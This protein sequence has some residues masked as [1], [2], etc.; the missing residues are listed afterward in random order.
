M[1]VRHYSMKDGLPDE[2]VLA[3]I[4]DS[5]GFIWLGTYSGLCKFDGYRF[6][7]YRNNPASSNSLKSNLINSLL[8]DER[9]RIWIA[10]TQGVDLFD[11]RTEKF[12]FHWPDSADRKNAVHALKLVKQRDGKIWI[13]TT[14]G[15]YGA[16]PET[17]KIEKSPQISRPVHDIGET[18]NGSIVYADFL[19]FCYL[20]GKTGQTIKFTH[21]PLNP[22]TIS[23]GEVWG[24]MI[25]RRDRIWIGTST[26]LELFNP[27]EKT[28]THYPTNTHVLGI[29]ENP[30]GTLFLGT[31]DGLFLFDPEHTNRLERL[32]EG[33]HVNSFTRDR[34][35]NIW[36]S[37]L[38]GL[39]QLYPNNKKFNIHNQFGNG[40]GS[41]IE[42]VNQ[43]I[44]LLG[45][46]DHE[47]LSTVFKF[48]LATGDVYRYPRNSKDPWTWSLFTD[49]NKNVWLASSSSLEKC[50]PKNQTFNVVN[51][52]QTS[53]LAPI[54]TFVDSDGTIW[55][56]AWDGIGKINPVNGLIERMA[57]FPKAT[58]YSFLEDS[59]QNLWIGSTAGLARYN[60]KTGKLDFFNNQS[61]DPQSLSSNV[62]YHLLMDSHKNIWVGTS[63]GLNKMIKG[64]ESNI[65]R[66]TNW[67]TS[68]SGLPYDDVFCI[69]D[70]GDGT[71]WITS[72]NM[73]AHF[74]P[75]QNIFHNYDIRDGLS[76][77]SFR[78]AFFLNGKG[79][80]NHDGNILFGSL[81]G[82][83]VFHPDSLE[84]NKFVP[85]IVI[86]DFSIQNQR[87]PVK[88][89]DADTLTWETPLTK[90]IS[91]TDEIRLSYDQNNFNLE[92]AAL[93][94]ISP[95]RSQYKYKLE[96]YEKDWIETDA[97]NRFAHYTNIDPGKYTF[98]VIGSNNDGIWNEK[99][100]SLVIIITPPWWKT[101][102]AYTL[103]SLALIGTF[104]FWRN[105][106]NKR[107]KLKHRAEH[108]SEL[109]NLKTRFFTNI[110]HEFRTPITLIL[111]PLKEMYKGT[112]KGDQRSV[113]GVMLRNAQ[114]LSKLINQLLDLS[115]LEAGKMKLRS[116]PVD[117]V[118]FLKEITSS[119]ES[120]AAD[121]KIKYFFYPEV[122]ELIAYIDAEKIEK[123]VHNLLSNAFKFTKEDGEVIINLKAEEKHFSISV[124]DTGIG[125]PANQLNQIF[126]RFYQVDSTQTREYEG[127]G[128]GMTLAKEL[129]ELHHGTIAVESAEG[130]G[131]TFIVRLPLGKDH[132]NKDEI[133]D[134]ENLK[135][136]EIVYEDIIV[137]SSDETENE[138]STA[139]SDDH[140]PILLIVEDNADMRHCIGKTF[141]DQ[142]QII[143]ATNGEE[144]IT[145]AQE[146]VPDL[147]ISD[148]MMPK[149]DGY[150]FCEYIKTKELTS[151]IPVILLTAKADRESKLTGLETG[152]D[153]YLSKPFDVDE[154]QLIVR[155]RIEQRKKIRERFSREITLE[156]KHISIS[157]FDEKFLNKVLAIVE[158]H[159]DD[160]SFSIEELSRESGYSNMHFYRKIKALTGETPSLFLRTI[161][162]KRAAELLQAKS[163]NVTQ[164]AYSVGFN[165]LSYFNKCFKGQFG[166]TPGQFAE[167]SLR[168]KVK[169]S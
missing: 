56:G 167:E 41:I 24:V 161:R 127:S 97:N 94:F 83:V 131:T 132:L 2:G 125:I 106:E 119:Y 75:K 77:R 25:D 157:S 88:G 133:I 69:V 79:L 26:G 55:A 113:I 147:I 89:T 112:F 66:F 40:I 23:E 124:K 42:D 139:P 59:N 27:Q 105:Y 39:Q 74:Y 148:V 22:K 114:R 82:L 21:D 18:K 62:V 103:Y 153:D 129:V 73:I 49:K 84:N 141:S 143:E 45:Y 68:Q 116:S 90:S 20:D 158:S 60:L 95:D 168:V 150:K 122:T 64:T 28:F 81:D 15:V 99:G 34:Q 118:Q 37:T 160:E 151:H 11:P 109:D 91:H 52:D 80:R 115:K 71:L 33:C 155:N 70:G 163:D 10:H 156:P 46:L 92:F 154:L 76:G 120:F 108:L 36:V 100:A 85:P 61:N 72:G 58:V 53:R 87:V 47:P 51:I 134:A 104:L 19:N 54:T 159:M 1:I 13:C 78:G 31:Q 144:G 98:R 164:I 146:V 14:Q 111:G 162:L 44:W 67:Q 43:D 149:V 130:K 5:R 126:N 135:K 136:S 30:D 107:L 65:P 8:E 110:S 117:L 50:D 12:V 165:N 29:Q 38:Q 57:S 32:T 93:N 102:W 166:I 96:P 123:V 140:Q 169:D 152:A 142:Y 4:Q 17:L 3:V 16:D 145:K 128:L 101:W 35:G 9:G 48:N 86:S 137:K 138:K 63:G 7:N 6:T 121:K